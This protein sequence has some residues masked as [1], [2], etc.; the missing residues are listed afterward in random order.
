MNI[1]IDEIM[2][3]YY[4]KKEELENTRKEISSKYEIE[5]EELKAKNNMLKN[6]ISLLSLKLERMRDNK[7]REIEQYINN[8]AS[9]GQD[10]YVGYANSL[11]RDLEQAYLE[12]ENK[13]TEEIEIKKKLI[14]NNKKA[15]KSNLEK[16]AN[17]LND[18]QK[19]YR[20]DIKEII[21]VKRNL[22]KPLFAARIKKMQ[23]LQ[24]TGWILKK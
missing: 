14:S 19:Y 2:R 20:V 8:V 7:E 15:I 24:T 23:V 4:D 22:R 16:M 11:R 18:K 1:N 6:D 21:E 10:F 5:N 9:N 12:H 13:L 3:P 17:E